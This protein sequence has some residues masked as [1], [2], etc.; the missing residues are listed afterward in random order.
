MPV[1]TFLSCSF[2]PAD[3]DITDYFAAIAKGLDIQCVNVDKGYT[4]TPP[5][6]ARQMITDAQAFIGV[7]TK[8]IKTDAGSFLM[9]KAVEDEVSMAFAHKKPILLF[10]EEGV[11]TTPGFANNYGTFCQFNRTELGKPVFVEK[12][13]N[14]IHTLKLEVVSPHEL[15]VQQLGQKDCFQEK[16]HMLIELVDIGSGAFTWRYNTTKRLRFTA[17]FPEP[18]QC[19]AW[20]AIPINKGAN[21]PNINW[22]VEVIGGTK[23]FTVNPL[24]DSQTPEKCDISL[25]ID[26]IPEPNDYIEYTSTF[27]SP[28]LSPIFASDIIDTNA[29]IEIDGTKYIAYDGPLPITRTKDLRVQMR[30]PKSYGLRPSAFKIFVGCFTNKIDYLIPSEMHRLTTNIEDFGGNIVINLQ[31]ES[32]LL[33]HIYGIAWNPPVKP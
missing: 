7:A 28:F 13:V 1:R 21:A 9:P 16:A 15:Q 19:A 30:F 3:K 29:G 25:V 6:K 24:I 14:S 10:V 31:T 4:A 20:A 26:P 33:Q 8:R 17:R 2:D 18:I 12:A 5:E 27:E 11:D 23:P 32:P 22:S